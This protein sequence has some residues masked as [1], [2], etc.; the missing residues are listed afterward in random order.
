MQSQ[1]ITTK[2]KHYP[3]SF[4]TNQKEQKNKQTTG[5]KTIKKDKRSNISTKI[6]CLSPGG[7]D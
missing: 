4:N 6:Y 2:T 5:T 1:N 7:T 3:V